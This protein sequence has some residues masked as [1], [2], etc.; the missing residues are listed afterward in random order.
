MYTAFVLLEYNEN[1]M[2]QKLLA[3]LEAEKELYDELK[4]TEFLDE[5]RT[6]VDQYQESGY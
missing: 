1:I 6:R 2:E 4:A 3:K 5:M